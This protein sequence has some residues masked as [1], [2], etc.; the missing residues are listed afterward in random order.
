MATEQSSITKLNEQNENADV[1][2]VFK[3]AINGS[4]VVLNSIVNVVIREWVFDQLPRLE[5]YLSDNGR[6]TDQLP[7]QDND[8]IEIEINN[9]ASEEPPIKSTFILQDWQIKNSAPGKQQ[10]SLIILTALL[11][12][13]EM[14][15]PIKRKIYSSKNS[16]EVIEEIISQTKSEGFE[17]L[18]FESRVTPKDEMNWIQM[19][20]S[21][22]D[23]LKHL[24]ERAYI[25]DNDTPFIYTERK[26]K[27]V[28]TSLKK[29]LE[30]EQELKTFKFNIKSGTLT[31]QQQKDE[32]V[33]ED[34]EDEKDEDGNVYYFYNW[35][36]KNMG[37]SVNKKSA[38]GMEFSY[39]DLT[40]QVNRKITTDEH[41]L[42][43]HSL[44]EKSV[45]EKE[46]IV[47]HIDYGK[48][49]NSNVHENYYLAM[50]QNKY[51]RDNFFSSYLMLWT[52][53]NDDIKLF[54]LV[55]VE[56]P[57]LLPIESNMNEVHSGKYLV[58][59]IIHNAKKD[60]IYETRLVLFRNGMDIKG[61]KKEFESRNSSEPVASAKLFSKILTNFPSL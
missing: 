50:T 44:K 3:C 9:F 6:F 1:S 31:S 19:D 57:S 41:P 28:Y 53:P 43:I 22:Y 54:D 24:L 58:G 48:Q 18:V 16:Q 33:E 26:G 38:Y 7:L 17:G 59:G 34:L 11:K 51:L 55:N 61:Y 35:D 2:F 8:E 23:F 40:S 60:S 47:R 39:Y 52:R 21:N 4:D 32:E 46:T 29:E 36:F 10:Q 14:I 27:M 5:L 20:Q 13:P 25:N 42:T 45:L 37:G 56:L 12:A 30:K 15:Y 49:D